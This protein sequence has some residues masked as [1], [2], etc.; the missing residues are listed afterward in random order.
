MNTVMGERTARHCQPHQHGP[1]PH[2]TLRT[3][4]FDREP[5]TGRKTSKPY[6]ACIDGCEIYLLLNNRDY[7]LKK[8]SAWATFGP[9]RPLASASALTRSRIAVGSPS[10][11][12]KLRASR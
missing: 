5:I 3:G 12:Q 11:V 2:G 1:I 7:P 8:A 10:A 4:Q 9:A 6:L